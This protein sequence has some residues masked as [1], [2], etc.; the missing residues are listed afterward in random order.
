[1]PTYK[2]N[3][4][5]LGFDPGYG[6]LGWAVLERSGN[7]DVLIDAGCFETSAK[8]SYPER[9]VLIG[10]HVKKLLN[11]HSPDALAMEKLF[12]HT[13]QKTAMN[14]AEVRG[15]IIFF[16]GSRP[17][18]EFTPTQ[19]KSSVCGYGKA[20]KKQVQKMITILLGLKETPQPDDKADAI[21][22]ALSGLGMT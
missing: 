14:V 2:I 19:V 17:V 7:K 1:M 20:D 4:K 9:L 3:K 18:Y 12:F 10:E 15:V 21:A 13:N 11:K 22:V 8:I 16:A 6:R 5:I